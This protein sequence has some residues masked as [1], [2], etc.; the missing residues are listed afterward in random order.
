MRI[1]LLAAILLAISPLAHSAGAERPVGKNCTL[2]TPPSS[3][4][5]EM[6]HGAVLR[7][8][9]RAKDINADYTGCQVLFAPHAKKWHVVALTEVVRG[10]PVRVWSEHERDE[11]V[12]ACRYK[13][14]NVVAGNAEK[15]PAVE[16][17]LVKSLAPGCAKLMQEAVAKQGLGAQHPAHC[18]YE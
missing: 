5:E 11:A 4:G 12:L 2:A 10:E 13:G 8:Y 18:E 15:C 6:N 7:I 9:P 16:S 14:G 1:A 3:A 17:L